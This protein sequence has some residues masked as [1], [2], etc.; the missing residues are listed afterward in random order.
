MIFEFMKGTCTC[1]CM[2]MPSMDTAR[3]V[4]DFVVAISSQVV[5][6]VELT[7]LL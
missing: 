5:I 4:E 2:S 7:L 3:E 6:M 1:T